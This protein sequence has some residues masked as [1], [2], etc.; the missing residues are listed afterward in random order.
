MDSVVINGEM[1]LNN[2]MDGQAGM[3][4]ETSE[5]PPVLIV[6]TTDVERTAMFNKTW[7]EVYRAFTNGITVLIHVPDKEDLADYY[8]TISVVYEE[9]TSGT[10][11]VIASFGNTY[12]CNG[13][14]GYPAFRWG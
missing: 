13:R 9:P 5:K 11:V 1:E 8:E 4:F 7:E 14:D 6:T 2:Q 10:C 3:V 12:E